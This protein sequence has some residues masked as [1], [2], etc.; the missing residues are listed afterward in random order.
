MITQA[1]AGEDRELTPRQRQVLDEICALRLPGSLTVAV[2]RTRSST[3]LLQ[4]LSA[5]GVL[6]VEEVELYRSP[7]RTPPVAR[8]RSENTP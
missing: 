3:S 8:L 1:F 5:L 4:R 2:K 6:R 7:W